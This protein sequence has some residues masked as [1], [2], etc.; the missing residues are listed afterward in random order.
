MASMYTKK[1]LRTNGERGIGNGYTCQTFL[2]Y[3]LKGSAKRYSDKYLRALESDLSD[4]VREG[5]AI[6][7]RSVRGGV[8]WY[9]APVASEEV[10]A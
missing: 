8:A 6:R 3:E 2:A 4:W 9:P 5:D 10:T 1:Y 7:G